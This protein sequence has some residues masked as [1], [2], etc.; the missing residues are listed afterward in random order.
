[1][2]HRDTA[3]RTVW[4]FQVDEDQPK[5][6]LDFSRDVNAILGNSRREAGALTVTFLAQG[7]DV[8]TI[9]NMTSVTLT[10]A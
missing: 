8:I 10:P 1:M 6:S 3:A 5:D 2:I 9:A 7:W 4:I